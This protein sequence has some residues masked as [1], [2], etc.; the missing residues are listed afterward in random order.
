MCR[1][2]LPHYDD[3]KYWG[4]FNKGVV[5]LNLVD[6]ALSS[7]GD[8][9][10]FWK[11][12]DERLELCH[13]ALI[14]R[15]NSLKG[16]KSDVAPILWQHGALARLK[17]GETIDRLLLGDYSS[18]SLGYAGLYECVKYMTG[19]SHTEEGGHEFGLE[20]MKHLQDACDK[21][22][23]EL[24]IG[25]SVY[26]SPI[27]STT[28]KFAK[29]LQKRFGIIEGIT[30]KKYVTNSYHV[31]PSEKIDAFSKL[32]VES[33]F[34]SKY[35]TGGQISYVEVPNMEKNIDA[36]LEVIKHIYNTNMYAEINTTTSYCHEC[37]C[38]DVKMV[39]TKDNEYKYVC[40]Q[41]GNDDFDKMN[42]AVRI[43]GY[44]STNIFNDGRANDIYDRV[45][46]LGME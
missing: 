16:A 27:E 3:N 17:P 45:Y 2:F 21:W 41:C 32:S 11:I 25:F 29:C 44:I 43:C 33:K 15:Y 46:H 7:D 20:V 42:I 18:I 24:N 34:S 38:T 9:E 1:S 10:K 31:T 8:F 14:I 30:D 35:S 28:Y 19:K 26:G 4:K 37:G 12:Y 6:V 5:T 40:P 23:E 13:R 36:L 22:N 39:K